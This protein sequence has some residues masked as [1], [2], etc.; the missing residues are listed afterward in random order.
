MK[1]LPVIALLGMMCLF[2]CG[3]PSGKNARSTVP[4]PVPHPSAMMDAGQQAEYIVMHYWDAFLKPDGKISAPDTSVINS[5]RRQDVEQ[6]FANYAVYLSNVPLETACKGIERLADGLTACE[7]ADASSLALEVVSL[8]VEHYLYDPNSPFRDEDIYGAFAHAMSRSAV[9]DP[10][11]RDSYA[12]EADLCALNRRGTVAADFSFTDRRGRVYDL[13]G[14]RAEYVV[15]F[16]SNPGCNAC[17]E[18]IETL[19]MDSKVSQLVAEGRIAVLNIYID[20]DLAAWYDYMGIYPDTWYNGYEHNHI[21]RDDEIYNVR[22][23]PSLYLLDKDK[24][25]LMKDVPTEKL[26]SYLYETVS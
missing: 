6:A 25:V 10:V 2:S 15:L 7:Q 18:I 16:F 17:K 22:A 23:I 5:V 9:V 3:N 1:H 13:H 19:T 11:R 20:D 4:F 8:D 21:I 24:V 14:I 12:A 26:M